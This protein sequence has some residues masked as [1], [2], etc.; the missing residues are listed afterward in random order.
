MAATKEMSAGDSDAHVGVGAPDGP[1][2]PPFVGP[3][4]SKASTSSTAESLEVLFNRLLEPS[5][6]IDGGGTITQANAPAECLLGCTRENLRGKA[7]HSFVLE[8]SRVELDECR[9]ALFT[10]APGSEL[11]M[12]MDLVARTHGGDEIPVKLTIS[13]HGS[14]QESRALVTMKAAQAP[15][16]LNFQKL[17]EA[18]PGL[19]LILTPSFHIAAASDS[20]LQATMT[21]RKAIEGRH[22]F[23]VFPDNPDDAEAT[24]TTNLRSSLVRVLKTLGTRFHGDPEIRCE[25]AGWL[26]RA[27]LLEPGECASARPRRACRLHHSPGAGRH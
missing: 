24:G 23:E 19:Y 15:M 10:T 16:E 17:F 12:Q 21:E 1:L 18:L 5:V 13:Q 20:Y 11:T 9:A 3:R 26:L 2:E 22:L 6:V 7:L 8:R 14:D 4:S 25:A 27:S